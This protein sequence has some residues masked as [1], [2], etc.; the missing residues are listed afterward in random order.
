MRTFP[1]LHQKDHE[2]IMWKCVNFLVPKSYSF[3]VIRDNNY[4]NYK[5]EFIKKLPRTRI[6]MRMSG[7]YGIH[8]FVKM[9][10][11]LTSTLFG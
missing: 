5:V 1:W 6:I 3:R 2:K 9:Y 10:Y 7:F 11:A 4:I 8:D